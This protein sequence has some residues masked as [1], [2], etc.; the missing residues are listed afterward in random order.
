MPTSYKAV[1]GHGLYL[2]SY[3]EREAYGLLS[4][5]IPICNACIVNRYF[6]TLPYTFFFY[7]E[8]TSLHFVDI[9]LQIAYIFT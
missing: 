1:L 3:A 7:K 8:L 5:L 6:I 2:I 9:F 4:H